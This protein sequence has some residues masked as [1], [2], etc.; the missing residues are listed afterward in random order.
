MVSSA[1]FTAGS[2][3]KQGH[4]FFLPFLGKVQPI[5]GS[6][7]NG[8]ISFKLPPIKKGGVFWYEP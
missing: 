5:R 8:G 6:A 2:T 3:A 1:A 7:V 4:G